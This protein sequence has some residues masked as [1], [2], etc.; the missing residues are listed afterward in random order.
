MRDRPRGRHRAGA[1]RRV[2]WIRAGLVVAVLS[3]VTTPGTFAFWTDRSDVEGTTITTGTLDL[4]VDD[5]DTVNGYAALDL[6]A[7]VPGDS[8]AAVLTVRNSGTAPLEYT[9]TATSS[10]ADGQGLAAAFEVRV[11][12]SAAVAGS[13]PRRT[14]AGAVLAG[15]GSTL[16]AGLV[17]AGRLLAAGAAESLCV[18]VT[19]PA[20][21]P[22]S[23]QGSTTDVSLAFTATSELS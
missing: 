18:E 12:G 15:T 22:A 13:A 9:A 17:S 2:P 20:D 1:R 19:L 23:L 7:M 5:Q 3:L 21:A 16:S 10:N 6:E 4:R 14:C 11:T 8:V